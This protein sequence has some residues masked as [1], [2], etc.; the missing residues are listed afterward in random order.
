MSNGLKQCPFCGNGCIHYI[1]LKSKRTR[2]ECCKCNVQ[3]RYFDTIKEL[4]QF[5]NKRFTEEK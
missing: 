2:L 5:W 3:T 1:E 4:K